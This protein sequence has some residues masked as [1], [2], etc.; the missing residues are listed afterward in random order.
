[1]PE[2]SPRDRRN[3][4]LETGIYRKMGRSLQ[5]A[6]RKVRDLPP[7]LLDHS[8]WGKNQSN[9]IIVEGGDMYGGI[10]Q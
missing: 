1:M 5:T 7:Q 4:S 2:P 8:R 9:A 10:A 3:Q 6:R